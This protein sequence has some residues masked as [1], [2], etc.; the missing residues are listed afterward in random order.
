[1]YTN[2]QTKELLT[3][4]FLQISRDSLRGIH[5][6]PPQGGHLLLECFYLEEGREKNVQ[7]ILMGNGKW[8]SS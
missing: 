4:K 2:V 1:M 8:E 3:P 5:V 7:Y 6:C